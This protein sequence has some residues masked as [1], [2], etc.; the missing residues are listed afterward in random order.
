[1]P[2]K[3]ARKLRPDLLTFVAQFLRY[4]EGVHC[5]AEEISHHLA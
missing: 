5:C 3:M 2:E 1:M 4:G